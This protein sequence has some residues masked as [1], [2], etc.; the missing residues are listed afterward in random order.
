MREG[1]LDQAPDVWVEIKVGSGG[2]EEGGKSVEEEV[3]G[4]IEG[5]VD[6][7]VVESPMLLEN[8]EGAVQPITV[9]SQTKLNILL[10][11]TPS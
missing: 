8:S 1:P 6:A 11:W 5:E 9:S 7:A 10:A 3:V 2:S 4:G